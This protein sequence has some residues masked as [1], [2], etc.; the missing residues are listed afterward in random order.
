MKELDAL[1]EEVRTQFKLEYD[2]GSVKFMEGFIERQRPNFE[3]ERLQGLV[4][5]IGSFIGAC[6]IKNYGGHWQ[7]DEKYNAVCVV[8]N[9][10]NKAFPFAK[11]Y[12]QFENGLED[13]VYSFYTAIPAALKL[14]L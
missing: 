14:E 4:N 10:G 7:L 5:A 11:T 13:S 1:A 9:N 8:F 6:M 3:G 2:E 12:K